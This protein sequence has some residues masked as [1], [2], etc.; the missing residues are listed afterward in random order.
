MG[1]SPAIPVL[2]PDPEIPVFASFSR[3]RPLG[4][5]HH[6]TADDWELTFICS[7]TA[8]YRL[9]DAEVTLSAGD[10]LLAAPEQPTPWGTARG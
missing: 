4:V 5:L 8:R 1:A 10:L 3:H 9:D 7:G 6:H 2:Y